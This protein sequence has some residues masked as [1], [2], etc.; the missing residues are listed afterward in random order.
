MK[1]DFKKIEYSV[2][3]STCNTS[4]EFSIST[5]QVFLQNLIELLIFFSKTLH[6]QKSRKHQ[7]KKLQ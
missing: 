3:D 7:V 5:Y 2:S 4:L 6:Y 1:V